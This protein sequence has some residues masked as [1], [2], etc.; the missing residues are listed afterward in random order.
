LAR[1]LVL[2][3]V[4]VVAETLLRHLATGAQENWS[5]TLGDFAVRPLER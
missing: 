2:L 4:S 3:T 5:I 1:N